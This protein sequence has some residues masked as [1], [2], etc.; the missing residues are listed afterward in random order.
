MAD[1]RVIG[2]DNQLPWRLPADL[3]HFK[4][5][6]M[7]KPVIMGRKTFE[8]IGRPLPGRR[9]IVVTTAAAFHAEGCSVAGSIDEALAQAADSEEIMIIG[10]GTLYES[11][12]DQARRIYLTCIHQAFAGDTFFPELDPRQWQERERVDHAPDDVNPYAY[13]F[14]V[15]ERRAAAEPRPPA[16]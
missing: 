2:Q 9:N 13:S 4:R 10:G 5:I 8:S 12:L 11:C 14:M 7:G 6:T 3:K 15:L 1:N 16:S